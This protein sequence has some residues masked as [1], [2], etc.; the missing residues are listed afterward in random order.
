[1]ENNN[2]KQKTPITR[3]EWRHNKRRQAYL[4]K[5]EAKATIEANRNAT[6][7][8]Y[9]LLAQYQES[10]SAKVKSIIEKNNIKY[11][12]LTST[13]FVISNLPESACNEITTAFEGC[14]VSRGT[15]HR[16]L[17]VTFAKWKTKSIITEQKEK[18]CPSNNTTEAKTAA[19]ARRKAKN[20]AKCPKF[21][22]HNTSE[23]RKVTDE[24]Q[25][26]PRYGRNAKKLIFRFGKHRFKAI[27]K[28]V[29]GS[30]ETL[31]EKKLRQRAQK[32]GRYLIKKETK[33]NQTPKKE[34][35]SKKSP[36][37]TFKFSA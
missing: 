32:A 18:K 7:K 34:Y 12:I 11:S 8:R 31:L 10:L 16:P 2:T 21:V 19:K 33:I 6:P 15:Q 5:K 27:S 20:V 23:K 25:A 4:R 3:K 14:T 28:V 22:K 37:Q 1:M 17:K 26:A 9:D 36:Q 30:K 29:R 13:Y 35:V 24:N